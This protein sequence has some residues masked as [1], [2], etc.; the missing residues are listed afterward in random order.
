MAVLTALCFF[1]SWINPILVNVMCDRFKVIEV[2]NN[3]LIHTIN[4]GQADAIAI[5]L[6]DG[7]VLLIDDGSKYYNVEYVK[8]LKENVVNTKNNFEIDYL[9][10]T[11]A[12]SDH[13]GGTMKLL[14]NFKIQE[15]PYKWQ[16]RREKSPRRDVTRDAA[17]FGSSAFPA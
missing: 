11:H 5:N 10:L 3:L 12:D 9:V 16:Y 17:M 14:K 2:N 8:Y 6:P 7:K 1:Q 4:V 13:I 15:G